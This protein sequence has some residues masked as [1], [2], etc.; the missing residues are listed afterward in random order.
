MP[1]FLQ[2]VREGST[3]LKYMMYKQRSEGHGN[4]I[5]LAASAGLIDRKKKCQEAGVQ[6]QYFRQQ[7]EAGVAKRSEQRGEEAEHENDVCAT[8]QLRCGAPKKKRD[9]TQLPL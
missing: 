5:W 9:V 7:K 1:L 2:T 8:Q 3:A 6:L 4:L